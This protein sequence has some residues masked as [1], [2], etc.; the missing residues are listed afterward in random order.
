MKTISLYT[1]EG[2]FV[3][4]VEITPFPEVQMPEV[5][6]WGSRTFVKNT[7]QSNTYNEVF[8]VAAFTKN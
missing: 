6:V 8:A 4:E 2:K 5:V 7:G 1:K 3:S